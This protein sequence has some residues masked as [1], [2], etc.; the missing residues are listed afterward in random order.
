MPLLNFD[1]FP[2]RTGHCEIAMTSSRQLSKLFVAISE[3][4]WGSVESVASEICRAQEDRGHYG[5]NRHISAAAEHWRPLFGQ[6]H[7]SGR[8]GISAR[9]LQGVR[10]ASAFL[11]IRLRGI[12]LMRLRGLG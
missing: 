3:R 12:V 2:G 8:S 4:D 7:R 10:G 1:A 5:G 9:R 6:G 11:W